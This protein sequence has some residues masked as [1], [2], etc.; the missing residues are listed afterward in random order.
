MVTVIVPCYNLENYIETSLKSILCQTYKNL[1]IIII[2]DGSQDNSVS[3]IKN[4][5]KNDVRIKL[6][7]QTNRGAANARNVGLDNA[8]GQ[9]I[10]FLDGDDLLS[11]DSIESNIKILNE[12][13]S[14][15]WV[16]FPIIR[17]DKN[18]NKIAKKGIFNDKI[19]N[20]E[21]I[22]SVDY[23]KTFNE[24]KLSGVCCGCLY[25]R[26][27]IKNIRFPENEFYEDSFFFTD[28]L[29]YTSKG[30][31]SDKG[32]Y[33]YVYRQGSSQLQKYDFKHLQ[34][35]YNLTN[36][37]LKNFRMKFPKDEEIYKKWEDDFY[38][39]LKNEVSKRTKGSDYFFNL[40]CTQL[41]RKPKIKLNKEIK[42]YLYRILGY[43]FF[44]VFL[45][46]F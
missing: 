3:L 9:F 39:F 1:E 21:I 19:Y 18:G 7:T 11:P 24:G 20:N 27:V 22:Y 6:I 31:L 28:L 42:Y 5:Q 37:R 17:I 44:K 40:F 30:F 14:F 36:Y 33:Y 38:Y 45:A 35:R 12:D 29:A 25:R 34:S 10:L 8:S 16:A 13:S 4:L 41:K 46:R 23:I 15:D 26:S 43:R 32:I 2:D